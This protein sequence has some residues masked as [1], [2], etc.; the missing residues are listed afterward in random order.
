MAAAFEVLPS[1]IRLSLGAC[2]TDVGRG[3][4]QATLTAGGQPG[5]KVGGYKILAFRRAQ[6]RL[7]AVV[8]QGWNM[9]A[10]AP[11]PRTP[12]PLPPRPCCLLAM[13]PRGSYLAPHPPGGGYN[14]CPARLTWPL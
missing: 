6:G 3:E 11:G 7:Q 8:E 4:H 13:R 12:P 2:N 10:E 5:R 14:L 9:A 1:V